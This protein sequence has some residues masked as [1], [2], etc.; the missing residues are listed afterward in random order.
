[1]ES[2]IKKYAV[3]GNKN[4]V[5]N[6]EFYITKNGLDNV[7]KEVIGTHLNMKGDELDAYAKS[8]VPKLWSHFDVLNEGFLDVAKVPS[9]LK[10]LVGEVEVNNAL[11]VQLDS[12]TDGMYRPN[13][14]QS[15][16]A[17]KKEDL[18]E[19]E[20][21]Q[22][23]FGKKTLNAFG[24]NSHKA[25]Y[26]ERETPERYDKDGDDTLMKSLI[27]KYAVEGN[28]DKIHKGKGEPNGKFYVDKSNLYAAAQEVVNTHLGLDAE[29]RDKYVDNKFNSL[30]E[31]Y[32]VNQDGYL[33][34]ERAPM[35]LRQILGENEASSGLQ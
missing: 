22:R 7:A 14:V 3:E 24:V 30:F 35:F 4:G 11:T 33:E 15:P 2:L 31:H 1:M 21:W 23:K 17:E 9:L 20:E 6:G 29:K 27:D 34:V 19:K 18:K 8:R 28:T 16:W 13:I 26:Y 10:M 12:S 5:P 25:R 32:D